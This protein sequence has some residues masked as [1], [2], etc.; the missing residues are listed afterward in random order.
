MQR[1]K[2]RK[3][4]FSLIYKAAIV[5]AVIIGVLLQCEVGTSNFSLSSFR[6]FATLS[7][8]A[9]AIFFVVYIAKC[10]IAGHN[11]LGKAI[12]YFK[13]LITLSIMLTGLV[14]HFMLQGLFDNMASE[15]KAGLTLLHYVVPIAIV[16]DWIIFDEKGKTEFAMPFFA[17]AFP[18]LYVFITMIAAPFMPSAS[19]YPYP[20]LNADT[21]GMPSVA[22]NIALLSIAFLAVGFLAVWL[23]H[24][25]G[26][27]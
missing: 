9:V 16:L 13:F 3:E 1:V 5:L 20:F 21:L 22:L 12:K 2:T 7:N 14:A 23:D 27:R 25:L 26:K 17:A 4:T 15:I 18:I 10:L 19:R 11:Q 6:M 8:C 24:K